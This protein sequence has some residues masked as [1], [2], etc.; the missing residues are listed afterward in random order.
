VPDDT[1]GV[2]GWLLFL[3]VGLT[4]FAPVSQAQIAIKAL[5]NLATVR[6]PIQ[7]LLRLGTVGT[8]YAGLAAFSCIAGVMLWLENPK[9]VSVAKAYFLVAAAAPILL[10][11]ALRLSGME[12]DL[13]PIILGRL[14]TS[15]IWYAYL[16]I[17]R[18]VKLTYDAS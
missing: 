2:G 5:R 3:C 16:S 11:S 9:G 17:S 15:T 10:Y 4:F 13:L 1:R 6:L 12:L 7:T 18:R 14:A 8:I